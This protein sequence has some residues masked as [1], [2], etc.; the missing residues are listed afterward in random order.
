MCWHMLLLA[1]ENPTDWANMSSTEVVTEYKYEYE[2]AA[3][4]GSIQYFSRNYLAYTLV[5]VQ[6]ADHKQLKSEHCM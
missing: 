5:F 3:E 6:T 2:Q 4:A 1:G